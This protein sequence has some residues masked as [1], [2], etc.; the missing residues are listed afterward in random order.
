MLIFSFLFYGVFAWFREQACTLVCP[1]GRLQS[2]L[3]DKNSIVV[4]YDNVRGEP[5]AP[6]ERNKPRDNVGD[7]VE[8]NACVAVCPTGIDIRHGTQLECV[9]CT[10]C[11]DACNN[12]MRKVNLPE[13]LIRYS[14][15][16]AL[17]TRGRSLKMTGRVAIYGIIFVILSTLLTYLLVTRSDVETTILRPPGSL[18]TET[19]DGVIRNL[20]SVKL[21]NKTHDDV[22]IS[23]RVKAPEAAS[24]AMVGPA[25][26]VPADGLAESGFFVDVP[27]GQVY[28]P[29]SLIT[30]EVIQAGEVIE[31]VTVPFLGPRKGV[32]P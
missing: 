30:I 17:E 23:F 8:C 15:E 19:E 5:R 24:I 14:S 3:L 22:P 28:S 29:N 21:I 26:T 31:E 18:Y 7:C 6:M 20:Y 2:V 4:A 16:D 1:Y 9:N 32:S 12:T 25:P 11:I 27:A 10:A 13:G